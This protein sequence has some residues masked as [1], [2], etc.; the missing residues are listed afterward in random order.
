MKARFALGLVAL[1]TC[2][3]ALVHAASEA[4]MK[5]E[6][7]K[8]AFCKHIAAN[9]ALM[10]K[11]TWETH[12]IDNG[13]LCVST[14]PKEMKSDFDALS[15]KMKATMEQLGPD[16]QQGQ[17]PELCEICEDMAELMKEGVKEK[18]IELTNGSIH[19]MT[20]D[21]PATVAKIHAAADKAIEMQKEIAKQK[22]AAL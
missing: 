9:P 15:A 21:D 3:L 6:M 16:A 12:K 7:E 1:F 18:T 17:E 10:E 2:G 8:C 11:M 4:E 22:T 5:A 13:M 19:M 20:S 14:V